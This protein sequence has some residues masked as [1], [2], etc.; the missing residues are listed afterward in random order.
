MCFG[1]WNGAAAVGLRRLASRDAERWSAS[2]EPKLANAR[3]EIAEVN[4]RIRGMTVENAG[5][6]RCQSRIA[7]RIL[8]QRR[9][10]RDNL[11]PNQGPNL[12]LVRARNTACRISGRRA[13]SRG[14]RRHRRRDRNPE[15]DKKR[16]EQP[17]LRGALQAQRFGFVVGNAV[18]HQ[19]H[20]GSPAA[21]RQPPNAPIRCALPSSL[22]CDR[23]RTFKPRSNVMIQ[24]KE[25]LG[26]T[27]LVC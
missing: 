24:I 11:D 9:T 1:K 20:L 23:D 12:D 13:G 18:G 2:V 17:R 7:A 8:G 27:A 25:R 10:V 22:T 26:S 6:R 4:D 21:V 3:S 19:F 5:R 16:A 14:N 15:K